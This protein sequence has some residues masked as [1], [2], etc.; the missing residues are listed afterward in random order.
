M[1]HK[2]IN[3]GPIY[4]CE[5]DLRSRK[6]LKTFY[7]LR[8]FATPLLRNLFAM[9][10]LHCRIQ[11]LFLDHI[12]DRKSIN[13]GPIY[14]C[15]TDPRLRKY[16]EIVRNAIYS[17][18]VCE[19]IPLLWHQDVWTTYWTTSPSILV[20]FTNLRQIKDQENTSKPS[21]KS[22]CS[23]RHCFEIRLR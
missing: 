1:D 20:Q 4:K 22:D 15:E 13:S 6:Y 10:S 21:A 18:F 14:T 16:L 12:I 2:S 23:Q 3:S 7:Q 11:T 19:D 9:I 8:L 17:K 5:T